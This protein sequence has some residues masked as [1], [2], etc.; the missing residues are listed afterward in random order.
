M[1]EW[2]T[3]PAR[4]IPV[5][6]EFD[7]VVIGGGIAGVAAAL[8]A[9]RGGSSVCLVEKACALGGLAT[10]GN[11]IIYLPLCDG[12]GRQVIGGI[13]EELLKLSVDD[14]TAPN[15]NIKVIPVPSCWQAGGDPEERKKHRY[16]CS[17]NP[18][19]Y[20]Y[21]LERLLLKTR[22]KFFY[23]M[24]FCGVVK[25]GRRISAVLVESKSGRTALRCKAVIDASGDADVCAIAGEK[26]QSLKTNVCCGWYYYIDHAG[27]AQLVPLTKPF[28][29]TRRLPESGELFRGDDVAQVTKMILTS[30]QLMMD[31]L[32][33]RQVKSGGNP[34]P[35]MMP[36]IPCFRMTRRLVGKVT[37]KPS[38]DH[39]WFP[40]TLGMTGDWRKAGPVYCLPMRALAAVQ[41]ANLISAGRCMAATGDT[42]DVTRVIP[43]CAVTGEAAGA[44]AAMLAHEE[45][46]PGFLDLDIAVLQR[47]LKRRKVIID[48]NALQPQE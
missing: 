13:G 23:D 36:T 28:N 38:D 11:V 48:R 19:T 42:W 14:V 6:G 18:I 22:V 4:D 21:K 20:L 47:N 27:Q 31:D 2:I 30:R 10:I 12:R 5:S 39:R 41:T 45:N 17:Y 7:V 26:T 16:R 9:A 44:A 46:C 37:L 3:E 33:A 29:A 32:A 24:R 25:D 43:T 40:D 1:K 8:A 34:Y 15:E 35:I